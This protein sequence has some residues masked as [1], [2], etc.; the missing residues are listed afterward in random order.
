MFS[1]ETITFVIYFVVLISIVFLSYQR[2]KSDTQ[3]ILGNRSLNFYLTALSAH[4]SDMSNW[5]FMGYP[6]L[7]FTAGLFSTWAAIGLIIF[8]FLN[9]QF[10]APRIRALTE[11]CN[12]LTLNSYF[13]S[14]FE[15]DFPALRLTSS[16]ISLIFFI[17]YISAGL[18]GLGLL[19]E[20]LFGFDYLIVISIGL[21][22]VTFYVFLG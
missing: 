16:L 14:Y 10:V 21:L 9:W 17:F 5:L 20:S 3:F 22:I 7:V 15:G 2:Q 1:I 18:I 4:A 13:E 12:D 6:A 19:L 11:K 8:M